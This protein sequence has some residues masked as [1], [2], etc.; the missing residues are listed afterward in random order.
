MDYVRN[1]FLKTKPAGQILGLFVLAFL[2][3]VI[4]SG[5]AM[6]VT[7][8]G[9]ETYALSQL[10][11]VVSSA[12][13][14]L[15]PA[16]VAAW[17]FYPEPAKTLQLDFSKDKWLFALLS[18]V[19][20][21][22]IIPVNELVV[23]WNQGWHLPESLASVEELLRSISEMSQ[24]L[25][26]RWLDKTSVW[27]LLVNLFVVALCPAVM[28][29]LFFRGCLQQMLTKWIKRPWIAIVIASVVFS[30]FHGDL[31]GLVPRFVL[32]CVLGLMFYCTNSIVPNVCAHFAN[33]A[34]V[35]ALYYLAAKG[36]IDFEKAENMSFPTVVVIVT[37]VLFVSGIVLLCKLSRKSEKE[38][39]SDGY[40]AVLEAGEEARM[41]K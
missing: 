21:L 30:I 20:M 38:K 4:V 31:F 29:E 33:N 25:L 39:A 11:Q 14:F 22:L 9:C 27:A 10:G 13:L 19:M 24:S 15:V 37:F 41:E 8:L 16:I 5:I 7:L 36:V 23:S 35:V 32:G 28:E 18:V 17:L 34:T 26:T 1:T 12:F 2:G 3:S 6:V 40:S